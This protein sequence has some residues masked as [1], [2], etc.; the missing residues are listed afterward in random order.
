[1]DPKGQGF[2]WTACQA[3]HFLVLVINFY[4][5]PISRLALAIIV[6]LLFLQ[7]PIDLVA[8]FIW[9][10]CFCH[11]RSVFLCYVTCC[12]A[13]SVIAY[14]LYRHQELNQWYGGSLSI[15]AFYSISSFWSLVLMA[16]KRNSKLSKCQVKPRST[17]LL[18]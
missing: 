7:E 12:C 17:R 14:Q 11:G 1:M 10:F 3:G 5:P 2:I 15:N 16:A 13:I 9:V 8:S 18:A 6:M 4:Q